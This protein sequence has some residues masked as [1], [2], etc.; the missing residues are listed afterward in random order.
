MRA[1]RGRARILATPTD[2]Q[3]ESLWAIIEADP[4]V[5]ELLDFQC[6]HVTLADLRH[7]GLDVWLNVRTAAP[8]QSEEAAKIAGTCP[9]EPLRPELFRVDRQHHGRTSRNRLAVDVNSREDGGGS[10]D[11]RFEIDS[12]LAKRN[13]LNGDSIRVLVNNRVPE[14]KG[15][16]VR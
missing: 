3:I 7:V 15:D 11:Q 9:R 8:R 2:S 5:F 10:R 6:L 12:P 14:V 13:P 1:P 4:H 16:G